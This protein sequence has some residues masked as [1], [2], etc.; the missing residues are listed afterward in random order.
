M[1]YWCCDIVLSTMWIILHYSG[2][3][4][5]CLEHNVNHT[6]LLWSV[7][8]LSWVQYD[9][10][11]TTLVCCDIVLSTMWII[12]H[13]SGLLWYCLEY[14]VVHTSLLFRKYSSTM[15][16]YHWIWCVLF[17]TEI[18]VSFHR[19]I[20]KILCNAYRPISRIIKLNFV[21]LRTVC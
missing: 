4:W 1:W 17:Q 15:K 12:L 8:I 10:Y 16:P 11:F 2:L 19:S 21:C 9:S 6:S 20:M 7:V 14:N 13:Y 18:D 3:L 5:Y